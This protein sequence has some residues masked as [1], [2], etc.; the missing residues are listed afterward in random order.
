[1][2]R[3]FLPGVVFG[4]SFA[5]D[6]EPE[7]TSVL[8]QQRVRLFHLAVAETKDVQEVEIT[9]LHDIGLRVFFKSRP[10]DLE[11]SGAWQEGVSGN[12]VLIERPE[13]VY[14]VLSQILLAIGTLVDAF[15][16]QRMIDLAFEPICLLSRKPDLSPRIPID[17]DGTPARCETVIA[18]ES[19]H[20]E[21]CRAVIHLPD[22]ALHGA[23]RRAEQE[24][25]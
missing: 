2:N 16:K 24:E 1:A 14:A 11:V 25:V 5:P 3:M 19:V 10:R 23:E 8:L 9:E 12:P 15:T 22:A 7:S 13:F 20:E 18:C 17:R 4:I 6:D 21:V